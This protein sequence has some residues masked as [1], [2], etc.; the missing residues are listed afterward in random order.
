MLIGLL[1]LEQ[2]SKE[3]LKASK[4]PTKEGWLQVGADPTFWWKCN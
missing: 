1:G 2:R 4:A 3:D